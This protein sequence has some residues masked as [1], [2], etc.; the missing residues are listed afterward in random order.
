MSFFREF[1]ESTI[2]TTVLVLVYFQIFLQDLSAR[3]AKRDENICRLPLPLKVYIP[4]FP[5][6]ANKR[7]VSL[8]GSIWL[9]L[10]Y[11]IRISLLSAEIFILSLVERWREYDSPCQL[12]NEWMKMNEWNEKWKQILG[13]IFFGTFMCFRAPI[14]H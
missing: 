10:L 11:F 13:L 1:V 2:N 9:T 12:W 6:E 8:V 5:W 4:F 14:V 7:S 3:M